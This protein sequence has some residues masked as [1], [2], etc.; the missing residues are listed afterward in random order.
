MA[1]IDI[2]NHALHMNSVASFVSEGPIHEPGVLKRVRLGRPASTAVTQFSS[3]IL[4]MAPLPAR[5]AR[6]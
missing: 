3:N 4:V 6:S 1:S 5:F 2:S